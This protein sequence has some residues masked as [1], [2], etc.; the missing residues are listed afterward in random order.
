MGVAQYCL[1]NKM[2]SSR[3][4]KVPFAHTIASF[5]GSLRYFF[6]VCNNSSDNASGNN[7]A[8]DISISP[9]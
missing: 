5:R 7:V 6:R 8:H 4:S 2:A 1:H 9:V 3:K